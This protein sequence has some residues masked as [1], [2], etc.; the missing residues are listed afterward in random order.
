MTDER[1][2][3]VI[4]LVQRRPACAIVQAAYGLSN[5]DLLAHFNPRSWLSPPNDDMR[6]IDGTDDEFAVFAA[7]VNARYP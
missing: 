1:R 6:V 5:N 7:D 4:D 3:L 2:P